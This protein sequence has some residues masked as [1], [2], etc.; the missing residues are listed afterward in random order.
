VEQSLGVL[1]GHVQAFEET[2][3]VVVTAADDR[4]C[5]FEVSW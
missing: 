1:E 3:R 5:T 2:P 4:S